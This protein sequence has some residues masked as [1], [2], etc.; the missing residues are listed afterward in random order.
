MADGESFTAVKDDIL[1]MP[2]G[3]RYLT[4]CGEDAFLHMTINFDMQ[5]S[6]SLPH[7]RHCE[8]GER[9]RRDMSRIISVWA[10]RAPNYREKSMGLLYLL[11]CDQLDISC[12]DRGET[13][14]KLQRAIELLEGDKTGD[15]SISE[16]AASC[17]I[18]ETY[19]RRLFAR[20]FGMSPMAYLTHKRMSYACELLRNT[21]LSVEDVCYESGYRDPAYFCRMF[22]KFTGLPPSEYR[23]KEEA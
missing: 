6:L 20:A 14:E 18:S 23:L 5:G 22:K 12:Q 16:L 11:L 17:H 13:R 2:K 10:E 7:R 9:S 1:Y 8:E 3:S 19:F 4:Q 15:I 21:P